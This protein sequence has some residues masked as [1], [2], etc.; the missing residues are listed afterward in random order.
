MF[1]CILTGEAKQAN[2][3]VAEG[4]ERVQAG[5]EDAGPF[6]AAERSKADVWHGASRD[7][8]RDS[9]LRQRHF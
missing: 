2:F 1:A 3:R 6:L 7:G 5:L 8:K 9:A 4:F